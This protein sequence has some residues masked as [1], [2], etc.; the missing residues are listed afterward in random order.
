M[1]ELDVAVIGAGVVGLTVA[2]ALALRGRDVVVLA[3]MARMAR[4]MDAA[5]LPLREE[6]GQSRAAGGATDVA[7]DLFRQYQTRLLEEQAALSTR[8][9]ARFH[10]VR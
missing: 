2:R 8:W 9:P 4:F 1:D 5:R 7:N 6:S 3:V 10:R